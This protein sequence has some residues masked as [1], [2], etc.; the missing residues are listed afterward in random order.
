M[1]SKLVDLFLKKRV[2][3]VHGDWHIFLC[4]ITMYSIC[5]IYPNCQNMRHKWSY[6]VIALA[7]NFNFFIALRDRRLMYL[8]NNIK[9]IN[10][11]M[12]LCVIPIK[13]IRTVRQTKNKWNLNNMWCYSPLFYKNYNLVINS[14]AIIENKKERKKL[15]H[16]NNIRSA[17][18]FGS[19]NLTGLGISS[20]MHQTT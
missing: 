18:H 2:W 9:R 4:N 14:V 20:W 7:Q 13:R 1:C 8:Y 15:T 11:N 17:V 10:F 12:I 16:T 3:F 6:F 5:L 19:E